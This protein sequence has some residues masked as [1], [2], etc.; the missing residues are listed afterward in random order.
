M[1]SGVRTE[2]L[3]RIDQVKN[4]L[5]AD[6]HEVKADIDGVK[7]EIHGVKAEIHELRAEIHGVKAEIHGV[8]AEIH[9]VKAE[10]ARIAFLIEEQN[11][12]NKVVLDGLMAVIDRQDRTERR[13]D[14]VEETVRA[15]ASARSPS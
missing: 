10:V 6:I 13:M 15:L 9:E 8:K 11:A 14:T 4:E 12:R 2:L 7:A 5:K 3:E 1:L